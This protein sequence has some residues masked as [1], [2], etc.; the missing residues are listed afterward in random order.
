MKTK[1]FIG[2]LFLSSLLIAQPNL[3]LDSIVVKSSNDTVYVW[4][5]N[6]WEQ[7]GFQLDYSVEIIDSVI[8]IT[9]IDTAKDGTTCYGY[10]NFVV[11]MPNLSEGN[12]RIDIYR[13]CLAEDIKFIKSFKFKYPFSDWE[14]N[15]IF[16]RDSI[17]LSRYS[18]SDSCKIINDSNQS[19]YLDSIYN[20]SYSSYF[21]DIKKDS[22][23]E[24][25][26]FR[27]TPYERSDSIHLQLNPG[28]TV[29]FKIVDVDVC[30][31]CKKQ[32]DEY[33]KDTLVFVFSSDS[34]QTIEKRLFLNSDISLD[35]QDENMKI[36]SY[37]LSQNFPNPF[38]PSTKIKY[39]IPYSGYVTLKVYDLLGKLIATLVSEEKTAGNYEINFHANN[40]SSGVYFY[41]IQS[42]GFSD[43]KKL[44]LLR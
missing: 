29:T 4:D 37:Y 41:R 27:I 9:Q 19:V 36:N 5:Y 20:K 3:T 31:I 8:T 15:I 30:P 43:A 40:L 7:C 13:D 22:I 6:A 44:L 39:T 11:P 12:Y 33:L 2:F 26:Y 23:Y 28:D 35:I 38:N 21:C 16:S 18:V 34:N 25:H 1:I 10:H 14:E 32:F 24:Y 42:G 17:F